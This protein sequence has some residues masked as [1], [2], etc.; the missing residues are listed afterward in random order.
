M[1]NHG[2]KH[3]ETIWGGVY[4][5]IYNWRWLQKKKKLEYCLNNLH[6]T[7]LEYALRFW[8]KTFNILSYLYATYLLLFSHPH[9]EQKIMKISNNTYPYILLQ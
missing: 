7:N 6:E 3:M 9:D 5:K 1:D 2:Y 8:M 4:P